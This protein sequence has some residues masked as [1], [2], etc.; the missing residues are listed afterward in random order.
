LIALPFLLRRLRE[1]RIV[2]ETGEEALVREGILTLADLELA[3]EEERPVAAAPSLRRA[4]AILNQESRPISLGR[5]WDVLEAMIDVLTHDCPLLQGIEAAGA[6]R[7]AEPLVPGLVIVA[8]AADPARAIESIA[9]LQTATEVLSRNM[10][11]VVLWY[12]GYEIDVRVATPDEYGTLLFT[13]TG[14]ARHVADVLKRRGPRL[15]ASETEVYANAGLPY[16]PAETRDS[17]DAIDRA[18]RRDVPP[19]VRRED[20]RGDLHM[21]TTYSDGRDS[22]RRMIQSAHAM[23]YEYIAITDHSEH[24]GA[25]RTLTLGDID[26][27]REEIMSLRDEA[28][29][30]TILH[31]IEVDILPDGSLDCPDRVL[32]SLDIVLASLHESAGQDGRQLTRRCLGA[33]R[34]P[35][36][37][38]ITHPTNRLVGRRPGYDMDYPAIY[39]AAAET[40]TAL[41]IDGAPPHLDLTG[42]RAREAVEAGATVVIDSDSH[43]SR[44][45]DRQMRMGVGTARRG[46]VEPRHVLNARSLAEVRAFVS[47]KR[48]R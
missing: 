35:L 16:L 1:L 34:H 47:N 37:S 24:A 14:P 41:E 40:G 33:I 22:M 18:I 23:G 38:V 6:V 48:S 43:R 3:I 42:E 45:L 26:R 20:I 10:R 9:T 2:D 13:T 39:H 32:E 36:V 21:H 15:S 19:L 17:P 44:L 28:P 4:A 11:R 27:Q 25:S 8:R 46:W 31:G 29:G 5:A 12:E 7:R 30:M